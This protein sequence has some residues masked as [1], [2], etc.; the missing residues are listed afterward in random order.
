[1]SPISAAIRRIAD[2]APEDFARGSTTPLGRVKFMKS[3]TA[4]KNEVFIR[5][6]LAEARK[7]EKLGEVPVGAVITL[8]DKIIARGYNKNITSNDPT[9][10][11][12]IV[13][14]KAAAQKLKNY[15]LNGCRMYV[16]I[17]PCPMCAGALVWSRISEIVFGAYDPKAGACGSVVNVVD[18]K[19][20][21]HRIKT[22]GGVLEKDCRSIIQK[23]F[24]KRR[25]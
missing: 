5:A 17:E 12:E 11:A 9:A 1:M 15:R 8:N 19:K 21:N 22:T 2:T 25:K 6:A 3:Q 16:T 4:E 18:H 14:L 10:H 7:A 23:F 20:L 24:K 13:A